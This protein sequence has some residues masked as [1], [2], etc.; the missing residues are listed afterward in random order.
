MKVKLFEEMWKHRIEG[1]V[2]DRFHTSI[3]EGEIADVKEA[4]IALLNKCKEFFDPE[5]QDYVIDEIDELI[6]S[7]EDVEDDVDEIDFLLDELY[8]FCD[9]Y[10]IW[11]DVDTKPVEA[12]EIEKDSDMVELDSVE[13]E[14]K[15]EA[16]EEEVIIG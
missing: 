7:F 15:P 5:E 3:G 9:G 8:D 16:S 2:S 13:A 10:R 1:E 6:E 12:P 11:I 4:S 14:E